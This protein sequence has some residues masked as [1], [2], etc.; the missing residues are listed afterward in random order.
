MER[1]YTTAE[2]FQQEQKIS[3]KAVKLLKK[4]YNVYAARKGGLINNQD[5]DLK[6]FPKVKKELGTLTQ[7]QDNTIESLFDSFLGILVVMGDSGTAFKL[8]EQQVKGQPL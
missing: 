6:V 5:I 4:H 3:L 7:Q 8:L 2:G 1:P